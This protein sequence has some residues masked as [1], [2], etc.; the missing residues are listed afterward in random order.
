MLAT[1]LA[2]LLDLPLS[3]PE[4][5]TALRS[6]FPSADLKY[7]TKSYPDITY[8]TYPSLQLE[9]S[10]L[11]SS[12]ST[13]L[14]RIDLTPHSSPITFT[15]GSDTITS[16]TPTGETKSLTRPTEFVV[17]AKTT[18][19]H[20]VAAFGEPS[21]KGGK[22]PHLPLFLEWERIELVEGERLVVVG[23]MVELKDPGAM[24]KFT[25]AEM[26][27]GLGG[28]WDRAAGWEWGSL[29]IFRPDPA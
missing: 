12:S 27:R 4:L 15:F 29:K 3:S 5:D 17:E 25:E 10:Y 18:A 16:I 11:P 13:P 26:K 21:K 1:S 22:P 14:D 28:L 9:L 24:Q 2:A 20:F 8:Q 7:T 23:V 6:L 19:R